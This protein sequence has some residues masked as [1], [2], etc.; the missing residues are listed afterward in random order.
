MTYNNCK[1]LLWTT[2]CQQKTQHKRNWQIVRNVQSPKTE[3]EDTENMN[4]QIISN[5][6]ES[7]IY[8][9]PKNKILGLDD[10]TGK[11]YQTFREE[12]I[13]ILLKQFQKLPRKEHFQT[14]SMRPS[15]PWY[16]KQKISQKKKKITGQYH[17]L[18]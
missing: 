1:R 8:K 14:L 17:W 2:K 10:F 6:I 18:T 3:P 16:L 7:V 15:S 11:L 13:S 12:L 4:R 9:L 5:E